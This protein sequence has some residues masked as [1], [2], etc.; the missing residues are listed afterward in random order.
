[1]I[2]ITVEYIKEP[3]EGFST[4]NVRASIGKI[5]AFGATVDQAIGRL[6]TRQPESFQLKIH[7]LPV[8]EVSNAFQR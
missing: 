2:T 6:I 4:I 8:T 1:M 5:E 7:Y 3:R